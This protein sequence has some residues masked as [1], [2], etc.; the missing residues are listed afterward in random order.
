VSEMEPDEATGYWLEVLRVA[1]S[2]NVVFEPC[3]L[4][5]DLLGNLVPHVHTHIVPR[6]LEDSSPNTPLK[7]WEPRPVPEHDLREQV[8][9][10]R[11]AIQPEQT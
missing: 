3:H 9:R 6:Y 10:L 8:A 4:N 2:L 11:T 1:R 7:P 5:Y